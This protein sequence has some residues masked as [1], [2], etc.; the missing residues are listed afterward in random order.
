MLEE[1][2]KVCLIISYMFTLH[3][4]HINELRPKDMED[5]TFSEAIE[6]IYGNDD[7]VIFHWGQVKV[8]V[9]IKW[10]ISDSWFDMIDM[11]NDLKS[12]KTEFGMQWPSQ[13]FFAFWAFREVDSLTWEITPKWDVEAKEPILVAKDIFQEEFN[14]LIKKVEADLIRQGYDIANMSFH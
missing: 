13:S 5:R 4:K 12:G 11:M 1:C 6:S 14:G 9:S 8:P 10:D 7:E 3:I 2:L